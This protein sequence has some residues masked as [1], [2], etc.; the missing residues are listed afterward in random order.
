MTKENK[1]TE[2]FRPTRRYDSRGI[3]LVTIYPC[4]CLIFGFGLLGIT[5]TFAFLISA[6]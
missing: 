3:R 1:I 6:L 5:V 2:K 4:S